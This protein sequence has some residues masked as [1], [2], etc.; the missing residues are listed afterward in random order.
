MADSLADPFIED[1]S[2]AKGTRLNF[3]LFTFVSSSTVS[4][5]K[6]GGY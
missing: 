4:V 5:A 6:V 3:L 2:L 1:F